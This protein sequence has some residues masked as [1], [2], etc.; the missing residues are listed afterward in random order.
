M[1]Q[2][3]KEHQYN[4]PE[5]RRNN[6]IKFKMLVCSLSW[7]AQYRV[8]SLKCAEVTK[9]NSRNNLFCAEHFHSDFLHFI[10]LF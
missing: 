10:V 2:I 8:C 3:S 1:P 6:K 4:V 9:S 5:M 7:H